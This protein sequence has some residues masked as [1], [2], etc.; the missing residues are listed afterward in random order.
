MANLSPDRIVQFLWIG[1]LDVY[2]SSPVPLY[3]VIQD[4]EEN[5]RIAGLKSLVKQTQ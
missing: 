4:I 1:E 2:P 3:Y 5:E